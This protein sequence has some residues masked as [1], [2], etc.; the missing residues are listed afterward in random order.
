M[1]WLRVSGGKS[2]SVILLLREAHAFSEEEIRG[3]AERAWGLSFWGTRGSN[4][5][6]TV[7]DNGVFLQAGPHL[8]SFC[9][10]P[11]PY[12]EKPEDDDEDRRQEIALHRHLRRDGEKDRDEHADTK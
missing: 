12:E 5:G 6:I 9:T 4:R 1:R 10:Q 11:H 8:L 2:V 3:A 7:S